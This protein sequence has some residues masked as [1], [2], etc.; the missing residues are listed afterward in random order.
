M[1]RLKRATLV[2]MGLFYTVAGVMHFAKPEN[3]LRIMPPYLPA[4]LALVFLSG[5]AEIALGVAVLFARTRRRAA[6]GI[7]G[8]LIAVFPANLYMYQHAVETSGAAYEVAPSVLYARLWL[9][10]FFILWAYWYTRPV[11]QRIPTT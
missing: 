2:L 6:W 4:R 1:S 10:L 5:G 8:L 11:T 3:Y 7:I 9:Q